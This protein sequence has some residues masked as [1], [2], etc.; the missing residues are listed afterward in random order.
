MINYDLPTNICINGINH[1]IRN[2]G[3]YR[4]VLDVIAALNDPDL[5]SIERVECALFIFYAYFEKIDSSDYEAALKQELEFISYYAKEKDKQSKKIMDWEQ[6][7]PLIIA[8][9]NRII[10]QEVRA[11][12]YLH[13]FTFLSAYYEIGECSFQF[14]IG[15]RDKL[16]RGEKL[17]KYEQ[18]FLRENKELVELN[19]K[20]SAEEQALLD[21]IK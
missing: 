8:P 18:K 19:N 5:K 16:N 15:L 13:W 21:S 6:D 2:K 3:D 20:Y 7:F 11:I 10:G 14:I 12:D 4:V 17:E 1:P 9:I